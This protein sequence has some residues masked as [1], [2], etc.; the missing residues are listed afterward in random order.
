MPLRPSHRG[1][2]PHVPL[3]PTVAAGIC[4]KT[5]CRRSEVWLKGFERLEQ[6]FEPTYSS[7]LSSTD[8]E[9]RQVLFCAGEALF[10]GCTRVAEETAAQLRAFQKD[11]YDEMRSAR[12]PATD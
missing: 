12:D 8:V 11:A 5:W 2:S 6:E 4:L 7:M 9:L 1:R 10:D 3:V